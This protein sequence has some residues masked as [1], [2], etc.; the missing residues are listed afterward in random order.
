MNADLQRPEYPL[1]FRRV[2]R[3]AVLDHLHVEPD[4]Q[5]VAKVEGVG[6]H[7]ADDEMIPEN[8]DS[9]DSVAAFVLRKRG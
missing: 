7:V 6:D 1:V 5:D 8:L 2:P 9:L 4:R 3:A